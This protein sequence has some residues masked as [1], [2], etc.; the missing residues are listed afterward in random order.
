[1]VA[2]RLIRKNWRILQNE[3][4]PLY[5]SHNPFVQNCGINQNDQYI[6]NVTKKYR[7]FD[8][9]L[10]VPVNKDNGIVDVCISNTVLFKNVFLLHYNSD[11]NNFFD[12]VYSIMNRGKQLEF[13]LIKDS[14]HKIINPKA[15]IF[16]VY[17]EKGFKVL[18]VTIWRRR[19]SAFIQLT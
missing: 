19:M 11:F 13:N 8:L 12:F 17:K 2:N 18:L 6:S 9:L 7:D 4:S 15:E 1:M 10:I 5:I 14:P 3:K 16:T